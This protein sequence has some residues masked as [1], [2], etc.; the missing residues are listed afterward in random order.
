MVNSLGENRNT[1]PV[2]DSLQLDFSAEDLQ[3]VDT[4]VAN[5]HQRGPMLTPTILTQKF[6]VRPYR[7]NDLFRL[8]AIFCWITQSIAID[9]GDAS[10]HEDPYD[11]FSYRV[12]KTPLGLARLFCEMAIA[13]G[14]D[15]ASI[16][17]GY[18]RGK[19]M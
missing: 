6:L 18:L 3:Q 4:Y 10:I 9:E 13:A 5:V 19:S 1:L 7:H 15:E 16:V 14:F 11:V 17:D 2:A 8:R 12:A